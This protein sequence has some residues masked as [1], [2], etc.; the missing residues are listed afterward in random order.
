[1]QIEQLTESLPVPSDINGDGDVNF[2]DMAILAADWLH[3]Q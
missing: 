1:M 3:I 2:A